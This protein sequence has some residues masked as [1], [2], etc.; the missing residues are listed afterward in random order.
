MHRLQEKPEDLPRS[1]PILSLLLLRKDAGRMQLGQERLWAP[2]R[3]PSDRRSQSELLLVPG[4]L[5]LR[6][7]PTTR[8]S[9]PPA[10]MAD[11]SRLRPRKG[12]RCPNRGCSSIS[13]SRLPKA[14]NHSPRL[15]SRRRQGLRSRPAPASSRHLNP[16]P[17]V[18]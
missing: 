14:L 18:P 5:S 11:F 16:R 4:E 6:F 1:R 9:F 15:S 13:G 8:T 10:G 7:Q 2:D 12:C 17:T 3:I